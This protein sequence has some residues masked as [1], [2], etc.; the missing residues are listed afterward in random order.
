[1]LRNPANVH[2]SN[3]SQLGTGVRELGMY[4]E[5]PTVMMS[6]DQLVDIQP[7]V[8]EQ[9]SVLHFRIDPLPD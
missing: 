1:M 9:V 8:V 7:E 2:Q 3:D 5:E 6:A 4:R